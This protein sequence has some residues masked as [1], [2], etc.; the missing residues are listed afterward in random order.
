M[1]IETSM[2]YHFAPT[3]MARIKIDNNKHLC[4]I[5]NTIDSAAMIAKKYDFNT[6]SAPRFR[7]GLQNECLQKNHIIEKSHSR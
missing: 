5:S 3:R 6:E 1:K 4:D 2:R 7:A